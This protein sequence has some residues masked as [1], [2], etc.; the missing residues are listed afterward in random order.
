MQVGPPRRAVWL[1]AA[2]VLLLN[3]I[4]NARTHMDVAYVRCAY[5]VVVGLLASGV[6]MLVYGSAWFSG[7]RRRLV[8]V[9]VLSAGA[10]LVTA[11]LINPIAYMMIGRSLHAVPVES[12]HTPS[13]PPMI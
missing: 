13:T 1:L 12:N 7:V 10:A 3:A 8:W 9:I 5:F 11:I 4:P 6:M 2:A